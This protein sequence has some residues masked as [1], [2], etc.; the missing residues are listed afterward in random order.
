MPG[1][2]RKN[3]S[4]EAR[5]DRSYV[6]AQGAFKIVYKGV[7]IEGKRAGQSCVSKEFKSGSVY[8]ASY[9]AN[10]L[11]V[12]QRTLGI[13]RKFNSANF[14]NR[15]VWVNIPAVWECKDNYGRK[16]LIE[17][18]IENFEKFNSNT[19][20]TPHY[21]CDWAE[22]MQALS[23][24]SY[25]VTDGEVLCCD[26]QGGIYRDGFIISDPVIMS[27]NGSYGPTDLGSR[28]ISTFFAHH[29]CNKFCKPFW[30]LPHDTRTYFNR[31]RGTCMAIPTRHSR[32]PLSQRAINEESDSDDDYY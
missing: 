5:I 26:L 1:Y 3:D 2:A 27:R 7:Y 15:P 32:P 11:K 21:M 16:S 10:E 17:P 25:D 12:V 18:M 4:Y 14:I 20:W 29:E 6:F 9:F 19:G 30:R 22:L 23:H 13:V 31:N 28:G 8:E 24:F